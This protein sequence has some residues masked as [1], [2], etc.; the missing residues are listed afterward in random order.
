MAAMGITITAITTM[1]RSEVTALLRL[2]S[3]LSPAFPVGAFSY[4]HG[5]EWAVEDGWVGDRETLIA[6]LAGDIAHGTLFADAAFFARAWEADAPARV[7]E[8]AAAMRGSA[9]LA[10]EA[11]TQGR[12]FLTTLRAAWP[13]AELDRLAKSLETDGIAPTPAVVAGIAA[14]LC[15][16]AQRPAIA[17]YLQSAV[18]NLISAAVRLVPLGQTDGQRAT[19]G[20]EAAI[21]EASD[22]A[23]GTPLDEIG[24]SGVMVDIAAMRHETQ[25]TRLFRS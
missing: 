7:A 18:A 10:L 16:A 11:E 8:L 12:A 15:G 24:S 20:L 5:L 22:R 23:I 2:H 17:L 14:R 6:W 3:W 4:S 1:P 9:E 19:A 25:Y 13:H 21:L